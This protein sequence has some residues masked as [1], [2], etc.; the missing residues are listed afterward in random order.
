MT[1]AY[2]VSLAGSVDISRRP[3]TRYYQIRILNQSGAPASGSITVDNLH[4]SQ[5]V[6]QLGHVV[7]ASSVNE[8]RY[9]P[10]G[11]T[12][13]DSLDLEELPNGSS[14]SLWIKETLVETP[15]NGYSIAKL[16]EE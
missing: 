16:L 11:V 12:F 9:P 6:V 13:A 5:I 7:R 1:A 15:L 3:G 10:K 4:P 14:W 8:T 2:V